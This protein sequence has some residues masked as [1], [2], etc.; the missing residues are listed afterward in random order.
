MDDGKIGLLIFRA[1]HAL[2]F[3]VIALRL[4]LCRPVGR[5]D[6]QRLSAERDVVVDSTPPARVQAD[7]DIIGHPPMQLQVRKA[8]LQMIVPVGSLGWR[9]RR[10][11]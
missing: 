1:R 2:A 6:V 3:A 4:L 10:P 7:G 8:A 9:G 11:T 5:R